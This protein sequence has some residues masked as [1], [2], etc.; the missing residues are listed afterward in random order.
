MFLVVKSS[1]LCYNILKTFCEVVMEK[2]IAK[3]RIDELRKQIEYHR[4]KYYMDDSPEISDFEFDAL[5]RELETLESEYPEFDSVNSPSK[6]VGGA[7]SEKFEKVRHVVPMGSLTDVFSKDELCS[8]LKRIE[9]ELSYFPECVVECKIDGLSVEL[10]YENGVFVRGATR[11]DGI[12]GENITENLLVINDIPK[13]LAENIPYL[14]V[15][16]EVYMPKGEFLRI[17]SERE[18]R[19]ESLFA[20]PRNAAAGSLRQLDSKITASR[21]L[22]I[23]VFNVQKSEGMKGFSSHRES[24]MYLSSLGFKVS[25]NCNSFSSEDGIY[26]EILRFNNERASYDFDI[27]G[28][29][30]KVDDFAAR[31]LIGEVANAPKWAVAYKY[32]PE[33]KETKLIKIAINVG[34]TG[35]LTPYAILEPVHLAG[36]VV[37]KA[38]LHNEDFIREKDI[39]EGD[40]VVVRKA[41]DIIPEIVASCPKMRCGEEKE[42]F[43]PR[44]CPDCGGEVLR[45]EN[46][47]AYRCINEN[48]PARIVRRLIHFVSRDA[49]NIDGLGEAQVTSLCELGL[50]NDASDIYKLTKED[51]LKVDKIADKSAQNLLNSIENSKSAGLARLLFA[52][53]IRHVGKQTAE[54]LAAHFETVENVMNADSEKLCAVDDIG[55]VVA[56]SI[57]AFF[58]SEYNRLVV[59]KL[60][61]L[62][63]DATAHIEKKGEL[64]TGKTFVI[65]GTLSGYS[66]NE[67]GELI[68]AHGGKVSS[69]V[70]KN[71]S[72]LL[73]GADGGSKLQKAEKLGVPIIS[74]DDLMSMINE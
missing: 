60:V 22:S 2:H 52:L 9:K 68:T 20:N 48:C 37:S 8:F 55:L 18:E 64:L 49:M 45:K 31:R 38:T 21:N 33:E 25:P 70:S 1:I 42:F 16:G 74:L 14:C 46:E 19:G 71:T 27:D 26:E 10:E 3:A 57:I 7:A 50:V 61:E 66:R 67:A 15:R 30:V 17:N 6:K 62:G 47:A 32:P 24:L 54:A 11:G 44:T 59:E 36:T 40:I 73:A 43:I 41:G 23:F 56:D 58:S 69:S 29:V 53:G 12:V 5:M 51:L 28:A 34:R 39:R 65:T 13:K 35:V 63:V 4:E 72:Y